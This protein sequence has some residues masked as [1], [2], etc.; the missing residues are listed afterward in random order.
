MKSLTSVVVRTIPAMLLALACGSD[1]GIIDPPTPG[2][3]A[4]VA[5]NSARY[6]EWSSPVNLG[7]PV[8]SPFIENAAEM[9]KDG[10]SLYFGSN[11]PGGQGSQDLWVAR[12]SSP[13][14]PW[15]T[16]NNLGPIINSSFIDAGP[17]LSSD[18]DLLYFNSSRPNG[19][20]SFDIWVSRR[21]NTQ[22]DLAWEAPVNI[23]TP[24]NSA[25]FDGGVS[26]WGS[27][28]YFWRGTPT[29][30]GATDGDIYL[31]NMTRQTFSATIAVA[32]L[33]SSFHDQR[34]SVRFDGREIFLSSERPGGEGLEDLWASTR[35]GNGQSWESPANLGPLV[36]SNLR[37]TQPALSE[38]GTMLLFAS[39]RSGGL[40]SLDLYVTTRT[41]EGAE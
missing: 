38:D 31:S 34:P 11:R 27:E 13:D 23:G 9:S 4:V 1:P 40:G 37:D 6:S 15:E 3:G 21:A 24:V 39:D 41:I 8:N 29:L 32:K 18:G 20:G 7:A 2:A 35:P 33:N 28:F 14:A 5:I 36:N 16:V 19:S 30:T 25:V 26:I 22:D 12:R 17:H 10:L